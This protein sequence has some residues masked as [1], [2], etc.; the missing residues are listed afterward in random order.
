MVRVVQLERPLVSPTNDERQ[1]ENVAPID[2]LILIRQITLTSVKLAQK[3][4]ASE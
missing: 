1:I 2:L 3:M 4:I